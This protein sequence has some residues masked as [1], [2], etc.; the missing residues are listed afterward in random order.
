[1]CTVVA[2]LA[3]ALFSVMA[4]R[5]PRAGARHND[6][7]HRAVERVSHFKEA[8]PVFYRPINVQNQ[9]EKQHSEWQ[10]VG[11]LLADSGELLLLEGRRHPTRR[12]RLLYRARST[13]RHQQIS[14][15]LQLHNKDITHAAGTGCNLLYTDT[16]LF[17]PQ[18]RT[19][20]EAHISDGTYIA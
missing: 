3:I 4:F 16:L 11:T 18:L 20:A 2:M 7:L 9:V 17:V 19:V 13:N 10:D 15:D 5:R 12:H 8:C 14:L 1:M 6:N